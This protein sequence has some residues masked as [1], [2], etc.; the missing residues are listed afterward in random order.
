M[1]RVVAGR[2]G[3]LARGTRPDLTF[4]QIEISTKFVNGKV[5][6]LITAA[7]ALRKTK[8][9]ESF[10]LIRGLGPVSLNEGVNST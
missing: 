5:R 3:W 4:A 10:L 1:L 9:G 2:I 6:D 7:K 8:S